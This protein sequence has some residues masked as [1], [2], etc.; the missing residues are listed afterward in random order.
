MEAKSPLETA[1]AK[2]GSQAALASAVGVTQ[3][4]VSLWVRKG[5]VPAEYVVKVELASGV[6]RAELRPD[7][8]AGATA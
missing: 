6:S 4:A 3:Q 7:M 5:R 8:F 2:V 1:I